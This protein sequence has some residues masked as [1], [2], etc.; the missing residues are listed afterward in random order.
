MTVESSM[1]ALVAMAGRK[2]PVNVYGVL[3]MAAENLELW[4]PA[5]WLFG[6]CVP[7]L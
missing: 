6:V 7:G 2:I 5:T 4:L 1:M 3:E